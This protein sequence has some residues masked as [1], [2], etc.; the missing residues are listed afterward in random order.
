MNTTDTFT[1]VRFKCISITLLSI[2]RIECVG[3]LFLFLYANENNLSNDCD[4]SVVISRQA[5][6]RTFDSRYGAVFFP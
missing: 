1:A 5:E 3:F 2:I 6:G 4:S